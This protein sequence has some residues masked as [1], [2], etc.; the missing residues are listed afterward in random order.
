MK[1]LKDLCEKLQIVTT[2]P[3]RVVSSSVL[4]N[5]TIL[6]LAFKDVQVSNQKLIW[7]K[8]EL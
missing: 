5:D 3:K 8:I 1:Y 7:A 2:K 4:S 6:P